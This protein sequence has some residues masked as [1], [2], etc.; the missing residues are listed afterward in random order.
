MCDA[1]FD[2]YYAGEV[3]IQ[4]LEI[5]SN[6]CRGSVVVYNIELYQFMVDT[7]KGSVVEAHATA[8]KRVSEIL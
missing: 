5:I 8:A 3:I 7:T 1:G 4:V 2:G 6:H